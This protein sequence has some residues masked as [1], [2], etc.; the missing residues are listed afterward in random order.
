MS[1]FS[2]ALSHV[3]RGRSW[4]QTTAA[5]AFCISQGALSQYLSGRRPAPEQLAQICAACD[6]SERAALLAA[7]LRDELPEA[8]RDL[9]SIVQAADN[10]VLRE[11]AIEAWKSAPL[12]PATRAALDLLAKEAASCEAVREFLIAAADMLR[13]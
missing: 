13:R 10:P 7:H 11:E 1:L 6:D 12:P 2:A 5:S 8:F 9:V 3:I 4:A